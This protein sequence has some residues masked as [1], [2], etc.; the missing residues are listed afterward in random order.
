MV[1][2]TTL[3]PVVVAMSTDVP[4]R[5]RVVVDVSGREIGVFRFRGKLYAYA[6]YCAHA[7]G[8]V[9]QGML[10]NRVVEMLDDEHRSLG[11]RFS[12]RDLHIVCP[13]HGYEYNVETGEHPASNQIRLTPYPVYERDGEVIVEIKA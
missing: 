13:W 8:P 11:D 5:G 12:E 9:C 2:E 10:I 1:Q 7:G 4:E 6:N 3:K